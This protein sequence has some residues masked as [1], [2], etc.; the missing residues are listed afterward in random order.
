MRALRR[1]VKIVENS[2]VFPRI[3]IEII[4]NCSTC[5]FFLKDENHFE[6]TDQ[7]WL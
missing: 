1:A 4:K 6:R 7:L 2:Y 5:E 3:K